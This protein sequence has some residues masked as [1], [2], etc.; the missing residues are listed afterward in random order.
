MSTTLELTEALIRCR[1]VTPNDANC[2]KIIAEHLKK[3]SF[4]IE[5]LRFHD[6][7]NLWARHGDR[8]PLFVFAGHTDV[9]PPGPLEAWTSDPFTPEKREGFLFG[10]GAA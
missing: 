8:G 2:Q 10:R 5:H 6:V 1:S 4:Q 3:L 9:V 7:D